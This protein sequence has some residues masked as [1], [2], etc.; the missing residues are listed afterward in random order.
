MEGG[1][2]GTDIR[3]AGC[4]VD[5]PLGTRSPGPG[6][7]LPDAGVVRDLWIRGMKERNE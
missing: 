2:C 1:G 4:G 5:G 3:G 6:V 7:G